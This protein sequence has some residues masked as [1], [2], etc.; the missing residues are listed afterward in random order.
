L[1]TQEDTMITG[2]WRDLPL[3][4]TTEQAAAVLQLNRRTVSNMLDRGELQ[5]VKIGK[6]WRVSRAEVRRLVERRTANANRRSAPRHRVARLAREGN[7]LVAQVG[8][9]NED[10]TTALDRDR[11][12]RLD[13]LFR[14]AEK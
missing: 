11:E 8:R 4:L 12:R 14:E 5:G 1:K 6:E 10:L 7:V 2:E 3:V 13:E 9:A